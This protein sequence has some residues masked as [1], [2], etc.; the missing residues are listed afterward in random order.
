MAGALLAG[1]SELGCIAVD[2]FAV[3]RLAR[4]AVYSRPRSC[5]RHCRQPRQSA[6]HRPPLRL[7]HR[8]C[9]GA[10]H[11]RRTL[12]SQQRV[13]ALPSAKTCPS[14]S[15]TPPSPSAA[16]ARASTPKLPLVPI[17]VTIAI[18]MAMVRRRVRPPT[19]CGSLVPQDDL[20]ALCAC[21]ASAPS[22]MASSATTPR[23]TS[24]PSRLNGASS[25]PT[26]I[27]IASLCTSTRLPSGKPSAARRGRST[28]C[29]R[30][31]SPPRSSGWALTPSLASLKSRLYGGAA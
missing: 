17:T 2:G 19:S 6:L 23:R 24:V 14:S 8:V 25:P 4:H 10:A 22:P 27:V 31:S 9:L 1:L 15:F 30:Q 11:R 28:A 5:R 7:R 18:T 20:H 29:G 3:H 21:S 12:A 16:R 13:S 26:T